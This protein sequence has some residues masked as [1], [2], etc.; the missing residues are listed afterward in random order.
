MTDTV[1]LACRAI[2]FDLD[3]T[4]IDSTERITRLWHWWAARRG[5]DFEAVREVMHG[6]PA[7]ETIR[8]A[9][10]HLVPEEE[11]EALE[12]EEVSDM[13]D[14]RLIPGALELLARLEGASWAIVTAGSPRVAEAR[15]GY[16]KLPRPPVLITAAQIQNGKPDPEGYLLAARRLGA[17]PEDCVVVED[18][19][20]GVEAGKAA[21]MRVVAIAFSHPADTLKEADVVVSNLRDIH[22]ETTAP[23]I[24]LDLTH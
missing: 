23:S 1:T 19:P 11:I 15:I 12:T 21:H 17:R 10:A 24:V 3:G 8:L 14:V 2:L 6:R 18:A 4:L 16:V 5:V 20:V 22:V 7:V 13:H 9:A